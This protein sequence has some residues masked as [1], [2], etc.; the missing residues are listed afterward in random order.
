M[1]DPSLWVRPELRALKAYTLDQVDCRYKLDQNEVPWDL[2]RRLKEEAARRLLERNWAFYPDFHS[3]RL[4]GLL[5]QR[6]DWPTDGVLVGNG[7]NELLGICLEA[8]VGPGT[9]VLGAEPSFGLYPMFVT[10][11]GGTPHFLAPRE[12]LELPFDELLAAV[13]EN[14][15]RPLLLCTPN[16][17]TGSALSPERVEQLLDRLEAPLL[18]DNAYGEFCRYDHRPLLREHENLV[19]F[20]TF[21]KAWSLGGM[22]LGYLLADP[23][24][25]GELIKVKLPYNL[26]HASAIIGEV[27]LENPGSSARAVRVLKG[28][29]EQWITELRSL[30]E[31]FGGLEVLASEGNFFL[32]R[33][34][35]SRA[36]RDGLNARGILVREVG[37]YPGLDGCLRFGVGSGPALRATKTAIAEILEE[38]TE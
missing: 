33:S 29:R 8:L 32:V 21:S 6:H 38:V 1:T 12:D 15:R 19:L 17:P 18:L 36:L 22:R 31:R 3:D 34:R 7:S 16:N 25:V 24:L 27:V 11:A 2:P 28:R 14:P 23:R 37:H 30:G 26:S 4:R 20:R 9:E 10:R 13:E 5:A 35:H